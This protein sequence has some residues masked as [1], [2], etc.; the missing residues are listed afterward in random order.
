MANARAYNQSLKRR[1]QLSLYCPHGDLK[2]LFINAQPYA[3]GVS[4]RAPTY[5]N[6]YIELIYTFYRLFGW[7]MRQITGFMQE[8]WQLRGLEIA[9]P[10]FGQLSERFATLSVAVRQRGQRVADR[11]AQ[12]KAISLIV[13]STGMNFGRASDWH[14]QKYGRDASRTP[15]RKVHLSIDA[16][17]N[18]H[19]I[20]VTETAVSDAAGLH[21]VLAVEAS[22][23]CV[24]ADGAYYSIAQTEAW[25][26]C[27]VLPVIPPPAKAVVHDQPTTRWHDQIVGYIQE[28]GIHAFHNK[29]GYG[30]R[31]R[32]EA[33]ISRIKRCIGSRLLTRRFE[34]QQREGVIIA[35]LV[36]LWNSFGKAVC[37][38]TA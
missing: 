10:S 32:V 14:R 21:A 15:W 36:N 16:E 24:I 1:G 19:A 38:K 6:A 33:Q 29:Y 35:N 13:D 9:V 34:S 26:A 4:G 17:M 18:I 3:P 7:A 30:K 5:T 37:V 27:G 20:S 28:K 8:Y 25:S 31:A 2:A 23:D 22:V 12:G 11:L